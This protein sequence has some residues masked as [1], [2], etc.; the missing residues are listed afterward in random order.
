[1]MGNM[2]FCSRCKGK[3][4]ITHQSHG[5]AEECVGAAGASQLWLSASCFLLHFSRGRAGEFW[6]SV[7]CSNSSVSLDVSVRPRAEGSFHGAF[8]H[9]SQDVPRASSSPC[10]LLST[11]R[12]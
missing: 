1:M 8:S 12:E 9:G 5:A 11:E 10:S 6:I 4:L 2:A 3:L 7:I